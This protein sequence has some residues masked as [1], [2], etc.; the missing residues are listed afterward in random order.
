MKS[1]WLL[2][3]DLCYQTCTKGWLIPC[4]LVIS[5][6][7]KGK[8]SFTHVTAPPR[9]IPLTLCDKQQQHLIKGFCQKRVPL[10]LWGCSHQLWGWCCK[11]L[12]KSAFAMT[13][14]ILND[15]S[16]VLF[17]SGPSATE[18]INFTPENI[19]F[20]LIWEDSTGLLERPLYFAWKG[21]KSV[22]GFMPLFDKVSTEKALKTMDK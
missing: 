1:H 17:Y 21:L 3:P 2:L 19:I 8:C 18:F 10:S 16:E 13:N 6:N 5:T 22:K 11:L 14:P 15:A 4:T 20:Y 12:G 7:Y 9:S